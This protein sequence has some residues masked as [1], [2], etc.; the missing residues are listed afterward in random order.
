MWN[1]AAD[2][3]LAVVE[4]RVEHRSGYWPEEQVVYLTPGMA[5]RRL[6]CVLAHEIGHHILGHRPA[7]HGPI[8]SRQEHAANEWAAMRLIDPD[9]YAEVERQRDGHLAS[10][11]H[12]LNVVPELVQVFQRRL[13]RVGDTVYVAPRMGVGGYQARVE[14]A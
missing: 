12:D 8:R 14:V 10:I 4:R 9:R 2:L 7:A 3:G 1:L 11:A 13:L 5:P 6:R